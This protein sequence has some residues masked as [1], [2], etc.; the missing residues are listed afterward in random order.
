MAMRNK[1]NPM[2]LIDC[3]KFGHVD[4][5]PKGVTRVYENFT[6]RGS[7]LEGV[8]GVV[9]F[10]IQAFLQN[11]TDY[12]DEFF[13]APL[14]EVLHDYYTRKSGMLGPTQTSV[15]HIEDLW[16]LGYL[17]LVFRALPEGSIC[18]LRVP[19][20]T[21]ENTHDNFA[22]LV[23]YLETLLSVELWHPMTSATIALQYRELLDAW[24]Y[25]T[26][27]S[28]EFVDWQGHDFSFRGL[29][30]IESAAASG[31]GHLLSFAGTDTVPALDWI[32]WHYDTD[33]TALLGGSVPATE[34]SVMQQGSLSGSEF[35]TYARLLE[36]YPSGIVSIV[37]D[38]FDLWEVLTDYLPAL[39]DEILARDGKVVIRPDSGDPVDILCGDA[40]PYVT[41]VYVDADGLPIE[42][43]QP[44]NKGVIE[45][46]W[47]IFGG[48]VNSKGYKELDPHIGAIYG[49]S[50]TLQ[51][52]ADICG[53][54]AA[55]GFASTNVVFGIG[56]FTY[57]HVTRDTLG[58]AMK[59]TWAMIDG[60]PV[61]LYKDPVTDSGIKKSAR[62]R[63]A[64][65][66][67]NGVP[68]LI[69]Q[70][71]PEQEASPDNLLKEIWRNGNF[72]HRTSWAEIVDRVGKR[73][74]R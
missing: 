70:A 9:V 6:P 49:D 3:Y 65:L 50:I 67:V 19:M 22:W 63:L 51:R 72:V 74:I 1:F 30:S 47:D 66:E 44:S 53:R 71:T 13:I 18:P 35:D 7:R 27:D 59:A 60:K 29:T 5:Q 45:I 41:D 43:W 36:T 8:D 61:D 38:T 56:S 54:L 4:Q 25:S 62:G 24:A 2:T 58:F 17:P 48:T 37:S 32:E 15:K 16:M 12:F 52:A 31:A 42:E 68:T 69:E 14:D 23:G 34:H 46:L 73:F 11:L 20:L 39:K 21:I 10:G 26:S 40:R 28:P 64:V 57:Q 33:P 55:K